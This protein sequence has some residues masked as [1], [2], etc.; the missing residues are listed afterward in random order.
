VDS[1]LEIARA[2][3]RSSRQPLSAPQILRIA[4]QMQLVP[5]DLYGRTQHKTLQARLA[6]DILKNRSK[7]EFFRT[8]PGRFFL[9]IYQSD[10]NIPS[11]HQREY[12]APLRAAQLGRFDVVAFARSELAGL[13]RKLISPF[14]VKHLMSLSWNFARLYSLRGDSNQ[15]PFRFLL[16]LVADGRVYLQNQKSVEIDGELN[17]QTIAG[18]EGM[19]KRSDLSLFSA[20]DLGLLDAASRTILEHFDLPRPVRRML[21]DSSRWS[22]ALAVIEDETDEIQANMITYISFQCSGITEIIDAINERVTSE[23]LTLPPKVNDLS[24]FDRS[25]ARLI[26][27]EK[28]QI[29]LCG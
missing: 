29:S 17:R 27:D 23:W 15:V 13:A 9:R 3:L 19:V 11:R 28:L 25:S 10:K 6:S 4:H 21:D 8:A 20:D 18:I 5:R 7:S 22:P 24:R 12:Q 1:Y 16:I 14:P 26:G 2:V